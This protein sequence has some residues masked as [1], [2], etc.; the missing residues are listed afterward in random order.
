MTNETH[1]KQLKAKRARQAKRPP[2]PPPPTNIGFVP[3]KKLI[4]ETI[5]ILGVST[6]ADHY[7]R[8]M[9]S[10][11][12]QDGRG[13]YFPAGIAVEQ[14]LLTEQVSF[15][16]WVKMTWQECDGERGFYLLNLADTVSISESKHRRKRK[17]AKQNKCK[18]KNK[19]SAL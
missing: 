13:F 15:P 12:F 9:V 11:R 1:E 16:V 18:P 7:G 17:D 6:W 14:Q 8:R 19:K 4:D 2:S 3:A 10:A 5:L